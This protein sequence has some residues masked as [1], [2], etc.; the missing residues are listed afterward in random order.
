MHNVIQSELLQPLDLSSLPD[1]RSMAYSGECLYIFLYTK[2]F[3]P[4]ILLPLRFGWL[5][6]LRLYK[7]DYLQFFLNV[8]PFDYAAFVAKIGWYPVNRFNHTSWL[9]VVTPTDRSKSVR[10]RCVI[11]VFGWVFVLSFCFLGVFS[12]D[13]RISVLGLSQISSFFS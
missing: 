4:K 12:V 13:V 10:L 7:E 8:C 9:A 6:V 2:L 11:V 3:S 5:L 1:M